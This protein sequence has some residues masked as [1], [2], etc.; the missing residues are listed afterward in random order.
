[1]LLWGQ[2]QKAAPDCF[3]SNTSDTKCVGYFHTNNHFA[4]SPDTKCVSYSSIQ[5]WHIVPRVSIRFH[6]FKGLVSQDCLH[7][8]FHSQ[9]PGCHLYLW[10]ISYKLGVPMTHLSRL[11]ICWNGSLNSGKHFVYMQW[12]IIKYTFQNSQM[13]EIHRAKY[14]GEEWQGASMP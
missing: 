5:L 6:R 12:F 8:R 4:N 9:V 14:G 3:Y 2:T 7:F 13:E 10:P 11:I 1:M